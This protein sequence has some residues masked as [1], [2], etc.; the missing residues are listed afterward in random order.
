MSIHNDNN[1]RIGWG[2]GE[3]IPMETISI[4]LEISSNSNQSPKVGD[5]SETSR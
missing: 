4:M 1:F 2:G 5:N 3:E